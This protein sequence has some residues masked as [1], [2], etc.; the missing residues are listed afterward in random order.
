MSRRPSPDAIHAAKRAGLR[1]RMVDEWRI[2]PDRADELLDEWD[3]EAARLG[4]ERTDRDY[5]SEGEVWMRARSG[6]PGRR[7]PRVRM[8]T[9]LMTRDRES[10]TGAGARRG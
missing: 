5:W 1:G 2:A 9:I 3:A 4:Q 6:R 7:W 10:G 8:N